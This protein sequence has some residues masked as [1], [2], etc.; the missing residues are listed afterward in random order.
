MALPA[1]SNLAISIGQPSY[2]FPF[3]AKK[4]AVD[5]LFFLDSFFCAPSS[6]ILR[7]SL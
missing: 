7:A 2:P 6:Q 5:A 1:L 3:A 4:G